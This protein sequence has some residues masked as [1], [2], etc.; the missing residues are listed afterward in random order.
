[1]QL[2]IRLALFGLAIA[3]FAVAPRQISIS[4]S[5]GVRGGLNLI[6]IAFVLILADMLTK[7]FPHAKIA[8][9][10]LKQYGEF[11]VPTVRM[12]KGGREAVTSYVR[13]MILQGRIALERVP[14]QLPAQLRT[15]FEEVK[16]GT[17]DS[18]RV[19]MRSIDFLR[20]IPFKEEQLTPS[21]ELREAIMRDRLREV[22]PTAVFWLAFN[23]GIAF[24]LHALGWMN[25]LAIVLWMLF[26]FL[27]DMVCVV[28]WCP[29]QLIFMRN[30]C[31][32]T[33][34]IFNWDAIMAVTPLVLLAAAAECACFVWPLLLL[35][36]FVLVRWE[37]AF[38]RHPE[39]FDERSNVSLTCANCKDRLCFIRPP[40]IK[41][42]T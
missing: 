6:D 29:I 11:Y 25:E 19:L 21:Q 9:G 40:L 34:Q 38:A 15:A 3:A 5:F 41:R 24:A 35:A 2:V 27:F 1:M 28:L 31:C 36:L 17:R 26:Y 14:G 42:N 20:L 33:C 8:M 39:R 4:E 12:F 16:A 18:L 10:S 32:T 23:A 13:E 22:V 30:R 7:C 37:L